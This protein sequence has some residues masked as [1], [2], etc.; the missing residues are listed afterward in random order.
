VAEAKAKADRK[1]LRSIGDA[2]ERLKG[3]K[4]A[5]EVLTTV[6]AVQ[7]I[8]PQLDAATRVGGWPLQRVGL[9]HGPSNHGKSLMLLGLGRSFLE[10]GGFFFYVDAEMT[11]PREWVE[12][13][14]GPAAGSERFL[15]QRPTSYEATVKDVREAVEMVV[16]AREQGL[17]D[18]ES[19]ALIGVDSIRKL[20]PDRLHKALEAG[21]GGVDG[22]KGRA[23][24][25]RAAL[26][27]EWMDELVP[28]LYHSHTALVLVARESENPDAGLYDEDF[29]VGGGK[30]IVYDS[31]LVV[32]VERASWLRESDEQGAPILGERF[33]GTVRK[34]KIGGKDD[35]VSRF[36]FHT[37]N[38]REAGVPEGFDRVRDSLELARKVGAV[39][40]AGSMLALGERRWRGEAS[41]L[42]AMREDPALAA[43]VETAGRTGVLPDEPA[44]EVGGA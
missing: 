4:P 12:R 40:A 33:R 9:V 23:A 43:A 31:S 13:L 27:A 19:S 38:G 14:L 34:T 32:R 6:E 30:A 5:R 24:Q 25:Y 2:V 42:R 36:Y 28:L 3:W 26:N 11:T 7:T 8:F 21:K 16:E 15:A 35:R 18:Q 41:L 29:R 10:A 44:E 22:M 20:V 37:G 39:D 17:I 1:R